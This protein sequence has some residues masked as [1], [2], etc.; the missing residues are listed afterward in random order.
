MTAN[1]TKT[2]DD[3]TFYRR[4]GAVCRRHSN[5]TED[6]CSSILSFKGSSPLPGTFSGFKLPWQRDCF[7]PAWDCRSTTYSHE[8]RWPSPS[9]PKHAS[10]SCR[11]RKYS[12]P[13]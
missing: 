9:R 6:F 3:W 13:S 8:L 4:I 7:G 12:S 11:D 10:L 2:R 5:F 1:R